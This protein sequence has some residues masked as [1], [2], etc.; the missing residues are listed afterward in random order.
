MKMRQRLGQDTASCLMNNK[1]RMTSGVSFLMMVGKTA[2]R[3]TVKGAFG[4]HSPGSAR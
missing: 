4:A 3:P 1:P 2:P